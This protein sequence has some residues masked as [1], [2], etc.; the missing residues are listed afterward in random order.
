VL[1]YVVHSY[2]SQISDVDTYWTLGHLGRAFP[3]KVSHYLFAGAARLLKPLSGFAVCTLFELRTGQSC[4]SYSV[5]ILDDAEL[6]SAPVE[7]LY[8]LPSTEERE[9]KSTTWQEKQYSLASVAFLQGSEGEMS[10]KLCQAL[11]LTHYL[12]IH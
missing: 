2:G 8:Y 11:K 1:W 10:Q 9:R 3:I 12:Y 4:Y 6:L 5:Q 7:S